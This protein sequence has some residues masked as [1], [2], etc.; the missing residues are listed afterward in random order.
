[1]GAFLVR[2]PAERALALELL[3]F[4]SVVAEVERTLEPHRLCGY[5]FELA[6]AYTSFYERCPVLKAATE[7]ER[8][9]RLALCDLTAKVLARGLDLLG[10]EA[11]ARM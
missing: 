3:R 11:P 1:K 8:A 6:S 7:E 4:G 10:I 5:L 9:S 2:D